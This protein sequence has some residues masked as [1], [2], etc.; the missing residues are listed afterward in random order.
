MV[1][2]PAVAGAFYAGSK[3]ALL[4]QLEGCYRDPF[5]PG[6]VPTAQRGPRRIRGLVVP[7]AGYM[8]SGPIAAHAYAALAEDGWP[9]HIV[10]LGPNHHG[11]G[12]PIAACPEDHL[13]PLGTATYDAALGRKIVGGVVE[14][15][16]H[17]HREEHSIEVQLPFLQHLNPQVS[18]VPIAMMFQEWDVAKEVGEQVAKALQGLDAVIIAS[19]DFTHVGP[20][21]GQMPPRGVTVAQFARE[22]DGVALDRIV[23]FDPKGLQDA[24]H[25]REITMCGY[26]AVTAM[27]VA[28]KKLG[29]KGAQ[30]LQYANSAEIVK[31]RTLAVGYGAVVVR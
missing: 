22:Q 4:Q 3:E 9:E 11:L 6:R 13:T 19:S 18:F 23:K 26:G 10:I 28:A 8:Y 7:H 1:R 20:N 16:P 25:E 27:L 15:D 24:V 30:L 31:D 5:G 17:A 2:Y 21:Y 29:A 12:A 14:A